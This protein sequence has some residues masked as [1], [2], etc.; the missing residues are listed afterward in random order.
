[1]DYFLL[2]NPLTE[3]PDDQIA[4]VANVRTYTDSQIVQRMMKRG[5]SL[6]E[7]D[8]LAVVNS[9]HSEIGLIIEEGDGINT[10][11]INAQPAI[12]GKFNS[13]NDSF[14]KA[15]HAVNYGVN[16]S[17]PIRLK[18]AGYRMNKVQTPETGPV[19]A[20]VKD[21]VSGLSDGALSA[22]G[23]LEISGKCLKIFTDIPDNGVFFIAAGG[24]EYRA[25]TFVENKPSRLIVM[26]PELPSGTYSLEIRTN[27]IKV[28]TPGKQL[29]KAR[30]GKPLTM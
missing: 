7:T 11:L 9:Y 12:G 26:I 15:R 18:I 3:D 28:A 6:T 2:D 30:F 23:V 14:D 19:V 1:M 29:R 25:A 24:T 8:I 10:A 4:I 16:F 27:F 17:K 22:G 20:S 13:V 5:T 21:S